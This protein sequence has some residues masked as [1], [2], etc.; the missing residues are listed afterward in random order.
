MENIFT[1][2]ALVRDS[3]QVIS[4]DDIQ[5][6]FFF[7]FNTKDTRG[8]YLSCLEKFTVELD[9]VEIS[10]Y[11]MTIRVDGK[12]Y[13]VALMP[14]LS[15]VVLDLGKEATVKVRWYGDLSGEHNLSLSFFDRVPFIGC[16]GRTVAAPAKDQMKV[17]V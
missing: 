15:S 4:Y 5:Y 6:G 14:E 13:L 8:I 9:G 17:G 16:T 10:P 1:R 3:F 2:T 7:R 12:E 11:D